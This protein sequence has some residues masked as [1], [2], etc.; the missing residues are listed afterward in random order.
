MAGLGALLGRLRRAAHGAPTG[1]AGARRHFWAGV[2]RQPADARHA[3]PPLSPITP[4]TAMA[5]GQL[6]GWR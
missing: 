2:Q 4:A 6:A 3:A 5:L 1:V